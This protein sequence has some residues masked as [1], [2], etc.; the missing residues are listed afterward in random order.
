M[1]CRGNN[2]GILSTK[3]I[4]TLH[5]ITLYINLLTNIEGQLV[6]LMV[7]LNLWRL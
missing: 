2:F 6:L 1:K 7:K 4:A 5:L 3:S